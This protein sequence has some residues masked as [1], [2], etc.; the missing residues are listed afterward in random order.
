MAIGTRTDPMVNQIE[1][2]IKAGI[3]KEARRIADGYKE[4]IAR[5]IDEAMSDIV[6]KLSTRLLKHYSVQDMSDRIVIEV[7]KDFAK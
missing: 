2:Y 1:E 5:D 4:Q 3:Q 6:A 7:K